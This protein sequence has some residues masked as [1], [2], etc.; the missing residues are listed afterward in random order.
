MHS[1]SNYNCWMYFERECHIMSRKVLKLFN[2]ITSLSSQNL[3]AKTDVKS[4]EVILMNL[5]TY[6]LTPPP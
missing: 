4:S 1:S 2:E 5:L 6:N 3:R